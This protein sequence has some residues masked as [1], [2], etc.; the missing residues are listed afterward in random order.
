MLRFLICLAS[1]AIL[2]G[3]QRPWYRRDAD[4][5][6]YAVEREHG[7]EALWPVASTSI[8]A[9]PG[10]R[11]FDPYSPDYPPIPPDDPAAH[12]YMHHPDGQPAP[13]T[14]HRDGD[15]P[16]IEDPSWRDCL[17]MDRDGR[18]VLNPEK[19]VELGLIHSRE[20]QQALEDLYT[21][22]LILTLDRWDFALHW[23]GT[24]NT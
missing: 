14:Y 2:G 5:Q 3:C 6:T 10:S 22:A 17:E 18:L 15:A 8:T 24:N 7:N 20:Y 12:F 9:P 16:W 21:K 13:R 11:L 1:L 4:R 23:F 19:A